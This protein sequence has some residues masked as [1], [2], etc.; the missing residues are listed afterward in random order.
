MNLHSWSAA[1]VQA[2]SSTAVPL[3]VEPP[4]AVAHR[5]EA[6]LTT[7][8]QDEVTP[9]A[10][11]LRSCRFHPPLSWS[12]TSVWVPAGRVTVAFTV[13]QSCQPPVSGT[14]ISPD[15]L[16]P[17]RLAICRPSVTPLGEARRKLTV[18]VPAPAAS[19]VYRNHCPL[20]VQPRS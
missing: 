7:S 4:A 15:R 1:L 14:L 16:V 20:L 5:P 10:A 9:E 6:W 18:Y 8:N 12:T 11:K 3:A 13:V 2:D 19:T 17:E